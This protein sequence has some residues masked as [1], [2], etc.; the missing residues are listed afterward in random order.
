VR[1]ISYMIACLVLLGG[2]QD[3]DPL[4]PKYAEEAVSWGAPVNGLRV[5]LARRLYEVGKAPD[6]DRRYFTLLLRSARGT[7]VRVLSPAATS[8][9]IPQ[10]LAGDESV[11]A[12]LNYVV[13][14]KLRTMSFTPPTRPAVQVLDRDH[15]YRL[16]LRLSARDF[17][18]DRF[19]AGTMTV[20]YVNAQSSI[21]YS[22]DGE[23]T[24]GLWTGEAVSGPVTLEAETPAATQPAP[25]PARQGGGDAR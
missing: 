18:V 15:D 17:G 6:F 8:G 7:E 25:A 22:D 10:K 21:R 20:T 23:V 12:R 19:A 16:E 1:A 3:T 5:G 13:E 11:A 24:R 9:T 14:G 4:G 2:C